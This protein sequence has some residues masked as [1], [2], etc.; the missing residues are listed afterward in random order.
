M[1]LK[2]I[3]YIYK[4][5]II[6]HTGLSIISSFKIFILYGIEVIKIIFRKEGY[7]KI[8]RK[9]KILFFEIN[10]IKKLDWA[11]KYLI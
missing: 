2:I 3:D 1:F 11:I 10:K 5:Y 9:K 4:S 6:T 7:I 8:I